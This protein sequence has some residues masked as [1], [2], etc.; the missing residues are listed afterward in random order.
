MRSYIRN[1][2]ANKIVNPDE[3]TQSSVTD[4]EQLAVEQTSQPDVNNWRD[5]KIT[6]TCPTEVHV[7]S[8]H[9]GRWS[10]TLC[11]ELLVMGYQQETSKP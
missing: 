2:W 8:F 5:V 10:R 11:R 1:G 6:F 3:L 7:L 4:V 9:M